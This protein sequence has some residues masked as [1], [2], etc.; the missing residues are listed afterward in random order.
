MPSIFMLPFPLPVVA[1]HF[2]YLRMA[3]TVSGTAPPRLE[4]DAVYTCGANPLSLNLRS[5]WQGPWWQL[6]MSGHKLKREDGK[7]CSWNNALLKWGKTEA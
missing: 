4:A 6:E 5:L 2:P 1:G 7:G 3:E